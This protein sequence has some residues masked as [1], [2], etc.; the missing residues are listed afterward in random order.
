MSPSGRPPSI[1]KRQSLHIIDLESKVDRLAAENRQ[2]LDSNAR[3]ESAAQDSSQDRELH[4]TRIRQATE[5]LASRDAII[6]E[7]DSEIAQIQD[8]VARL[9]QDVDQLAG[10]NARLTA[11]NQSIATDAHRFASLQ[12]QSADAHSKWQESAKALDQLQQEHDELRSRHQVL[13]SGME[14][15]VRDEINA[16]LQDR[17]NE[18]SRLRR[19]L[20]DAHE[21][22]RRLSQ[23]IA[24]GPG[25]DSFLTVR[26]DDYIESA[27][28]QLCQHVQ[29]WVLRFSKFSDQRACRLSTELR[30]D[31]I[32]EMLDDAM[33]DGS[34]VD[35]LLRDRVRRRDVFMSVVMSIIW[36]Y[37]FSR[38]LFGLDREQRQRLKALEGTLKEVGKFRNRHTDCLV[39]C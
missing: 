7:K 36:K 20:D 24:S 6:Q 8:M 33:V 38:Y 23:E 11:Q 29:Q 13:N 3:Y 26:N 21:E 31:K 32:E 18:I 10:E 1:R 22:I 25:V 30:D 15:I 39:G 2:L 5:A 4:A 28:I 37:V 14:Q 9:H 27:C 35:N 34:D 17:D 16:T 12:A 19:E